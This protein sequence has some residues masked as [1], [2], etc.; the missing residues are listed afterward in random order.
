MDTLLQDLRLA[1]RRLRRSPTFTVVAVAT[2]ALGIGANVAIFS[3]VHAV[4]LRPLPMRDDARL[5][6]LY[7]VGKQGPSLTSPPDLRD[8][9]EQARSFD[10]L[11]GLT[12]AAMTLGADGPESS[13]EKVQ[14]GLVTAEFFQVF[15]A[16]VQLGRGL[17][18][19]DDA[20][21][22]PRVAVLSHGLWQRRF[23]GSPSVMGRSLDLGGGA[24]WTVV[25]VA[26]PGFDFPARSELWTPLMW[27]ASM[28]KPEARGAHWLEVY[29][30]LAPG[31]SLEAARTEVAGIARG[32]AEQYPKTNAD[33]GAS[34][35]PLRDVLLGNVR[36]SLLLLLGAVGLVLLIACANLTHLLLARA[37]SREG[38]L[39]VR[40]ALG[41]SRGRLARELLLESALLSLLG[42]AAGLLAAMWAQDALALF[43]PRDIPR[44]DEVSLDRTVLA[45]TAG[46]AVLTTFLFGLVPALHASR[47]DLGRGLRAVSGGGGGGSSAHRHRTRSALIIGETALSVLLLVSAGLLLRSFVHLRGAGPGFQPEGVLTVKL[48]LPPLH[49]RFGSAAPLTFYD[50]LLERLRALPGVQAAGAVSAL[51]MEG[52]IKWIVPMKDAQRPTA[53]GDAPWETRVRIITPGALEA[54]GVKVLRGRGLT[55]EDRG[56]SGR[57]VLVNAEAARRFWPGENPVG[58]T[59]STEMDWGNGTFGGQVV[60]VVEDQA[61]DGLGAPA[62]PELFVPY[63][64]ARGTGMTLLLR[65]AGEPLA[66]ASAVR[67]EIRARDASL[68]LGSVRTLSSV[69]DGT[70]A[71]LRFY[72]MLVGV[73]AGVAL[74]LAAV[75]LYGVVAYA[76]L[77]RTRE[78]GIRMALGARERQVTGMVLGRYL[79]LTAAGL[80]LGLALAAGA[81]RALTHLLCGVRPVDPVTYAGV[82]G[83]LGLVAFLAAL[84]PAWRA[85]RMPPSVAL[86]GD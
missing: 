39:S 11:I 85:A 73:F 8:L 70:V 22:A 20:P 15:G 14:A 80:V 12:S 50:G 56:E 16:G 82:V 47:A 55:A 40:L 3:V 32:L 45:F 41:A 42:G 67:A 65:T 69:V 68:A 59:V 29:G 83:V 76:V 31:A 77:Q 21:G 36:P 7:T 4:L 19:G 60:G 86:R 64:Q 38:E 43:G 63:E 2:L 1:L 24:P 84:L 23:G 72:L 34:V 18:A 74:V 52:D 49:Y 54:L 71:P 62:V 17:Q 6:R 37:A 28:V 66:L 35:E 33:T 10:G 9:R 26:A 79:K 58:H 78:L 57:A 51:P 53:P 75:G 5:V 25:G 30:R 48:E 61:I 27:D 81:S 46:L 13:P 44:I